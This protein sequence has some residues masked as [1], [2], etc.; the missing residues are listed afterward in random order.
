MTTF[1]NAVK[2]KSVSPNINNTNTKEKI[3]K[4]IQIE[5]EENLSPTSNLKK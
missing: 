5:I 3:V 2:F 1:I 4:S